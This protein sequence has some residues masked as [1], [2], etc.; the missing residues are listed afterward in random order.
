MPA[1]DEQR[2]DG[3]RT[4]GDRRRAKL[5]RTQARL[6]KRK[7]EL[8]SLRAERSALR[9]DAR[10]LRHELDKVPRHRYGAYTAGVPGWEQRWDAN[11]GRRVLLYANADAAGSL[12]RWAEAINRHTPYAV[13]M[14]CFR[15]NPFG[16]PTDLAFPDPRVG[17]SDFAELVAE[18]NIV[19]V[20]DE[21]GFPH[22]EGP[23]G[24]TVLATDKPV[25]FTHYG[26]EARRQAS[27]PD[28]RGAVGRCAARV[29]TTPDLCFDW[30]DGHWVP[31]PI[32]TE[33]FP[34]EWRDGRVV[35]HSPSRPERKGTREFMEAASALPFE[36]E[37]IQD[38]GHTE[39]L[40]RK[41]RC[42][43]FFDQAGW[44]PPRFGGRPAGNYANSGLEAAVRGIPTIAHLSEELF[45]GAIRGGKD[46]RADCMIIN[47]PLGVEGIRATLRRW[48]EAPADEREHHSRQTRAW[49]ERVH[50]Y[51]AVAADLA[52]V[53]DGVLAPSS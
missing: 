37:L 24:Q 33:R 8:A 15:L 35:G 13:R 36:I 26:R 51:R 1:E 3:R 19:H 12:F 49:V 39:S 29:A 46:L 11:P 7:Q 42:N 14:A 52:A 25:V 45:E 40:E 38:V 43:L 41:R 30:F 50:S 28:Y 53:Y 27:D 4:E 32:D 48:L 18:A 17:P 34:Y 23:G 44:D 2:A 22:G 9:R 16:Y 5:E 20:K 6:A 31:L 10:L 21:R 47:T